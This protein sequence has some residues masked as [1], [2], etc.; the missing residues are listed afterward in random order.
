MKKFVLPLLALIVC[1]V[2]DTAVRAITVAT[3]SSIAASRLS[4]ITIRSFVQTN[5]EVMVA[6]DRSTTLSFGERDTAGCTNN[7]WR[8]IS[9]TNAP[10]GRFGHT[11][12]WTGSE[13]IIWGG[14][15]GNQGFNN[16]ARYN[17]S[18]NSWRNVS[19]VGAPDAAFVLTA[20]WTGSEMILWGGNTGG[21]Y[22]P[23][24]NT[25]AAISTTNA[26]SY[27][28][29]H[30]AVWTGSEMGLAS[31]KCTIWIDR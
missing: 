28:A 17:S 19:T 7:T 9:T 10:A 13:M 27:R 4:K 1:L 25:W 12:V 2:S 5:N 20:V 8:A 18:T 29:S 6:S 3:S 26:P 24:T 30:T 31:W 15:S 11:A 16:G 23:V 21:R 14:A 22:N